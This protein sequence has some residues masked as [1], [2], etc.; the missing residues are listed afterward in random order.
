MEIDRKELEKIVY[1]KIKKLPVLFKK[2]LENIE[3][4][5]EDGESPYILGLYHGVPFGK[6]SNYNMVMPDKII[7]YKQ[8]L[9]KLCKNK[10]ELENRVEKVLLHE[11]GH[12][13]GF[14]EEQLRN[15]DY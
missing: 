9:E 4:F 2:K 11:I 10:K 6:R 3:F 15:L 1:Q 13:F 8:P 14:S 5:V 12:Y 7:V